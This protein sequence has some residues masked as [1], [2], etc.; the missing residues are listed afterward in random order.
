LIF[1]T[2]F[3]GHRFC[4]YAS[5]RG[6]VAPKPM[7]Q[8]KRRFLPHALWLCLIAPA[9]AAPISANAGTEATDLA[10]PARPRLSESELVLSDPR[11]ETT[12]DL[13]VLGASVD[14][15]SNILSRPGNRNPS[16][17]GEWEGMGAVDLGSGLGGA[18]VR[19]ALRGYVN[20][21]RGGE[22]G[23]RSGTERRRGPQGETLGLAGVD[24]G[25]AANEW[26]QETVQDILSSALRLDVNQRGQTSFSVLG[27]GEF[28]INLSPDRTEVAITSGE[29]VL[30]TAQRAPEPGGNGYGGNSAGAGWSTGGT[31]IT[32][33]SSVPGESPFRQALELALELA[34][35][36]LSFLIYGLILAYALLWSVLSRR[37]QRHQ[38]PR[39]E[40][41]AMAIPYGEP[42]A[43]VR[44][45]RKRRHRSRASTQRS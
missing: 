12:P 33:G 45:R 29:T 26:I 19:D 9:H 21:P 1:F 35:H 23:P 32:A 18:A 14:A 22:S 20:V 7:F 42:P 2:F 30:V 39:R 31:S 38:M 8:F 36:P 34:S 40:R 28:S 13:S 41:Q 43:A 37:A 6:N 10:A 24:L 16:V 5:T 25:P 3:F 44:T 15:R 4:F 11:L 17:P 27:L